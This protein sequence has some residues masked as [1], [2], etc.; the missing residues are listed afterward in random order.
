MKKAT[1]NHLQVASIWRRREFTIRNFYDPILIDAINCYLATCVTFV[2]S[3][4]AHQKI[5]YQKNFRPESESSEPLYEGCWAAL[6]IDHP[7]THFL[8]DFMP[9]P[10]IKSTAPSP[11]Y[12]SLNFFEQDHGSWLRCRPTCFRISSSE[13]P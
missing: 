4:S 1:C 7:R 11:V 5:P 13:I 10:W 6:V 2:S 9:T 3:F 12:F 8:G